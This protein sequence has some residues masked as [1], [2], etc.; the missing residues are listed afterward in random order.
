MQAAV[1]LR[2]EYAEAYFMLGTA[3]KQKGDPDG[4]VAALREAIRLNPTIPGRSTR[5]DRRCGEGRSHRK[6]GGIRRGRFRQGPQGR[7][8]A[9]MMRGKQ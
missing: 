5:W 4:A 9:R 8:Q 1:K 7:E 2:P 6:P 3:L